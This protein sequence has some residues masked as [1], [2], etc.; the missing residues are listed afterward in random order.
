MIRQWWIVRWRLVE[1]LFLIWGAV[2]WCLGYQK[3]SASPFFPFSRRLFI[4]LYCITQRKAANTQN[5]IHYLGMFGIFAKWL[6]KSTAALTWYT[7]IRV[8]KVKWC[9]WCNIWMLPVPFCSEVHWAKSPFL[10]QSRG[11]VVL[12]LQW[13][14]GERSAAE[15]RPVRQG[16]LRGRGSH[17]GQKEDYVVSCS[18]ELISFPSFAAL[19]SIAV[20]ER[21]LLL[22]PGFQWSHGIMQFHQNACLCNLSTQQDYVIVLEFALHQML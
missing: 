12:I 16:G 21:G 1:V 18:G 22:L 13:R 6:L 9:K 20:E 2:K 4:I 10:P 7:W 3:S 14:G 11:G 8:M 5:Q 17:R 15:W 19:C